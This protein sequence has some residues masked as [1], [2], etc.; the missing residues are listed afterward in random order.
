MRKY[1]LLHICPGTMVLK[2]D[3]RYNTFNNDCPCLQDYDLK[4][5]EKDVKMWMLS[6]TKDKVNLVI[7]HGQHLDIPCIVK[8]KTNRIFTGIQSKSPNPRFCRVDE[9]ALTKILEKLK[10]IRIRIQNAPQ[11]LQL[12]EN[13]PVRTVKSEVP[14]GYVLITAYEKFISSD[15]SY[16]SEELPVYS[17]KL[18]TS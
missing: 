2:A 14:L 11:Y 15:H 13:D 4:E 8:G 9:T 17:N 18:P 10:V 12:L 3:L 6:V 16:I 1:Q 7:N 5:L